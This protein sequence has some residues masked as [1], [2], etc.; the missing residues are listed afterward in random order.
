MKRLLVC[1]ITFSICAASL[2]HGEQRLFTSGDGKTLVAEIVSATPDLV[3]LKLESGTTTVVPLARL[4]EQDRAHIAEWRKANP[5][6]IRYNFLVDWED[7]R[8]DGDKFKMRGST[9]QDLKQKWVCHF[10]VTNRSSMAVDNLE[11]RYQIHYLSVDGKS[12]IL[13]QTFGTKQLPLIRTNETLIVD[14]D[15]VTLEVTQLMPGWTW[16][17]GAKN[18]EKD[19]IKG[20][21]VTLV[22]NGK[23]VFEFV[24]R[25]ITKAAE[26]TA[27][28][29][30]K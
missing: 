10:K 25:G 29:Q 4:A 11:V 14:S 28:K 19:D 15:P 13:E 8:V 26:K 12:K 7:E 2:L 20:V 24:S 5:T 23:D 27:T 3:T 30:V 16:A 6:A 21:V 9:V 17:D 18:K 1:L 22:H